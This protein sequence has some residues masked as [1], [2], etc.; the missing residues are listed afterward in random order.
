M[1]VRYGSARGCAASPMTRTCSLNGP[2]NPS[3]MTVTTGSLMYLDRRCSSS[4]AE[5]G[6]RLADRDHV[7]TSGIDNRPS[8]RTSTLMLNSGLRHTNMFSLSPGPMMYSLDGSDE[9][10]GAGGNGGAL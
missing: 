1:S 7:L 9:A 3:A 5:L 6:W 10:G 4:R 8:G 2:T